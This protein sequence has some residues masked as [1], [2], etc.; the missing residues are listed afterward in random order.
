MG[1]RISSRAVD[2]QELGKLASEMLDMLASQK[3]DKSEGAIIV[4][5]EDED[6]VVMSE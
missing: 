3:L 1:G 5:V 6:L 4:T 2:D